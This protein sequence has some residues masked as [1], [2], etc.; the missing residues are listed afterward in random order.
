M[1]LEEK[2]YSKGPYCK[3][4][5]IEEW[6]RISEGCSNGCEFCRETKENGKDP[7]YY[8]IP[9][10]ERNKVKIMDM[11]ISEK[12]LFL[13]MINRLGQ[14]K[15]N[16]K[17]V[18]F[19]LI[20]GIDYRTFSQEKAN[21]LFQNHFIN[22]RFAWDFGLKE[23]YKIKETIIYL[24]RAGYR[25]QN[26]TCFIICNWKIPYWQNLE[27][28]DFLKVWNVKVCECWFNNQIG[29]KIKPV[30]WK[31]FEIKDFNHKARFHN[32]LIN[33][34]IDPELN[35]RFR[36]RPGQDSQDPHKI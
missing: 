6:I 9:P 36:T 11:N 30:Y 27:K 3:I 5:N 26:L 12:P 29:P 23:Q 1:Q 10:I 19:D 22:I 35:R 21:S 15:V 20:C 33:F 17:I 28:L 34:G 8:E 14:T 32:Q 31:E 4:G 25:P 16:N 18:Y 2:P 24:C 7:I 13:D